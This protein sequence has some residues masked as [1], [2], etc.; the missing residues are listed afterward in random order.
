MCYLGGAM[1]AVLALLVAAGAAVFGMVGL[2]GGV[3]FVPLFSW[4]GMDFASQAIP[5]SLLLGSLTGAFP[6]AAG[7]RARLVHLRGGG[8]AVLTALAGA[9]LG[10]QLARQLPVP[11]LK[12]AFAA[13]ACAVAYRILST[14]EPRPH[15]RA[16]EARILA[17]SLAAGLGA[18]VA[19]GLLGIGG[20]FVMV[21][22]LLFLGL[23]TP[24]AV[25]TSSLVVA[26]SALAGFLSHLP[27]SDL[28]LPLTF[29]LA[30]S[31]AAGV[32]AGGALAARLA[33]PVLLRRAVGVLL[34]LI[35]ARILW[36]ALRG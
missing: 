20:G 2:G 27:G 25:A 3:L 13:A 30:L 19:S 23:P 21:P 7:I 1:T 15:E 4:W 18:G 26:F 32:L 17:V 9:P 12:A 6:A 8:A 28:P 16:P 22:A 11:L 10:A 14:R 31:A 35:S 36:E 33:S 34:L 5:L 29:L 24:E